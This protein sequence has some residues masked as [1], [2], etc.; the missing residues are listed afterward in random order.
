MRAHQFITEYRRDKTAEAYSNNILKAFVNSK[1]SDIPSFLRSA[2]IV[3]DIALN[4]EK[5]S[6][7][8]S[9]TNPIPMQIG[10]KTFGVTFDNA[11]EIAE[12][13]KQG[14]IGAILDKIESK[15]PTQNKQ[16]SEWMVRVWAKA[17]GAF[18]LEDLNKGNLLNTYEL[19]KRAKLIPKEA[20]DIGRFKSYKEFENWMISSEMD[21]RLADATAAKELSRTNATK[22]YEDNT[23]TVIV[24]NDEAAACKYGANTK[25]CTAATKSKNYFN[26]YSRSGEMYII[27][28][29]QP[30]HDGEKYQIHFGQDE[31]K[32]E[33]NKDVSGENLL[34][35]RFPSVG[36]YFLENHPDV[37]EKMI[38]FVPD[39]ILAGLVKIMGKV[40][41]DLAVNEADFTLSKSGVQNDDYDDEE[42]RSA[43]EYTEMFLEEFYEVMDLTADDI[44]KWSEKKSISSITSLGQLYSEIIYDMVP[45]EEASN[46]ANGLRQIKLIEYIDSPVGDIDRLYGNKQIKRHGTV[47]PWTVATV[48]DRPRNR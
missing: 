43:E 4:P 30:A 16:F 29:K 24:P 35:R 47:G 8:I 34:T 46:V 13:I 28:P 25:W 19:A 9:R 20:S 12:Y 26:D 40:V 38:A 23:A 1:E 32:N 44:K 27:I 48:T 5:N 17:G 18:P 21:K 41:E 37:M 14:V 39:N 31:F 6:S 11:K 7:I 45:T 3:F 33:Y 42:Y 2:Q 15:D 22:V 10:N 36:K